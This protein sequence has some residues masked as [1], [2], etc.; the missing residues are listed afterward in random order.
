MKIRKIFQ[1]E[2]T[3]NDNVSVE[4]LKLFSENFN[5]VPKDQK[6]QIISDFKNLAPDEY[7]FILDFFRKFILDVK[8]VLELTLYD[9]HEIF[10]FDKYE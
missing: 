1:R 4:E 10:S 2:G 3:R 7:G 8:D 6:K 9:K 5:K